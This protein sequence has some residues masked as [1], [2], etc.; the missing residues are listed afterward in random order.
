M[1]GNSFIEAAQRKFNLSQSEA[2]AA[3]RGEGG[4]NLEMAS[5]IDQVSESIATAL[6]RAQVFLRSANEAGALSRIMLC[7]GAAM[8][9]GVSEFLNRRFGIPADIA[10]PLSRIAYDPGLFALVDQTMAYTE[11]VDWRY[12]R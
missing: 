12:K 3:V 4:G 2:A 10:N 8:T 1:G 9:P 5:V 6:E 7:G 11:H